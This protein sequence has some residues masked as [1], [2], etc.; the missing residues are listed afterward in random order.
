VQ[1]VRTLS[2]ALVAIGFAANSTRTGPILAAAATSG[3]T[4]FI[5]GTG[6]IPLLG[7]QAPPAGR[8]GAG[9]PIGIAA[10]ERLNG[11]VAHRFVILEFPHGLRDGAIPRG[12][13]YVF[14][15]DG[16]F[17]NRLLVREGL[18]RVSGA[19]SAPRSAE[20]REAEDAARREQRGL[21]GR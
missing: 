8:G 21:W 5:P 2:V 14:L 19:R 3:H 6:R 17:V 20:L 18:A 11:L 15:E 7:I 16:T 4:I 1:I 10:R 9:D 12:A 13:A